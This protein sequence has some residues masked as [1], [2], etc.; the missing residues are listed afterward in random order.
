[1]AKIELLGS[2]PIFFL[3]QTQLR[4]LSW[5]P[6]SLEQSRRGRARAAVEAEAVPVADGWFI[7]FSPG[8]EA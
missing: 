3:S 6:K 8:E 5:K 2:S 7:E 4:T 1:V